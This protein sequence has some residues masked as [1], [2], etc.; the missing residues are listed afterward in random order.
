LKRE[1]TLQFLQRTLPDPPWDEDS[2]RKMLD[3]LR[4]L[5]DYKYNKYEMYQPAR[6]FFEN[7]NLFLN[8]FSEQDR[9]IALRFIR[10]KLIF[11]SRE[12]FQQ[13]AHVLYYDRIRQ[14]QLD[15]AAQRSGIPRHHLSR[16]VASSDFKRIQRASLYVALSD[17][18]R[19]DYFRRQNLDINNEQVLA[20]YYVGDEKVEDVQKELRKELGDKNALFQCVFFL[21]D[22]CGSGRTLLREVI[23]FDIPA[24]DEISD[25][26]DNLKGKL[27]LN[28]DKRQ[29]EWNY[30]GP[31]S[32]DDQKLLQLFAT[33][34]GMQVA[35]GTLVT[36]CA[37]R[38][39]SIKGS[40]KRISGEKMMTLIAPDANVYL[41]PLLATEYS[42]LR[43]NELTPRLPE[44][45]KNLEIIPA[46][47][48]SNSVRIL[49]TVG[50]EI[51][52]LCDTY[53]D[54]SLADQHTSTVMYGY[55]DCG[56]P[57]VLHHNT[58]NN[59]LYFLWARKWRDPLFP[60]F[61]RHGREVRQ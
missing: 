30:K 39:T 20:A 22:F 17:G 11:V 51:A 48:I 3:D 37:E 59:S 13:L 14:K 15:L 32:D 19:I 6:L 57:I 26:P 36:A 38:N 56:L 45:L 61:E 24:G 53:Y 52:Q 28:K 1:L 33:T 41:A 27:S 21:D 18:A 9:T 40:L 2:L 5:A 31:I 34:S 43:L 4:V 25:L 35:I 16:L 58:P 23:S 60:R 44:P 42:T 12:E 46:A 29:L 55:D 47:T 10:D 50:G 7:L 8:R 54:K 49:S